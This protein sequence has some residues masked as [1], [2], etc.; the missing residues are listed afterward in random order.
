MLKLRFA[1]CSDLIKGQCLISLY[2]FFH[3]TFRHFIIFS[4]LAIHL[5]HPF[6]NT[7]KNIA[8]ALVVFIERTFH[9][10]QFACYLADRN[11]L[12]SIPCEQSK[13][14]QQNISLCLH[15]NIRLSSERTIVHLYYSE[16]W[17]SCQEFPI[18]LMA[19]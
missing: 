18:I 14:S 15:F 8:F 16:R 3:I 10:S 19:C 13:C 12:E 11:C 17:F 7:F 1:V 2:Y 5:I 9:H 6:Q 4:P